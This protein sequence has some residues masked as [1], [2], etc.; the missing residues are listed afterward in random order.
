MTKKEK[1][2]YKEPE[3]LR[4]ILERNLAGRKFRL[5]CGHYVTWNYHLGNDVTIRDKRFTFL[6]L[7]LKPVRFLK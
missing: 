7:N 6:D 4:E 1:A 5:Q 2:K 3:L